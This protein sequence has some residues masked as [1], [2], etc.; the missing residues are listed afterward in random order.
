[1]QAKMRM[2]K[3]RS[4][5]SIPIPSTLQWA[6]SVAALLEDDVVLGL[7]LPDY[8]HMVKNN[9]SDDAKDPEPVS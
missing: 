9:H 7:L 2:E 8:L 1:M 4:D 5:G 3:V 6:A